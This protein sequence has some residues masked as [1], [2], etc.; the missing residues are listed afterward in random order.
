MLNSAA[1]AYLLRV[2]PTKL[3]G[4]ASDGPFHLDQTVDLYNDT[5]MVI[6]ANMMV[7]DSV[8]NCGPNVSV[9]CYIDGAVCSNCESYGDW[10]LD[11]I[12]KKWVCVVRCQNCRSVGA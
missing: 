1:N 11:P 8:K 4:I 12:L 7:V 10:D 9:Y 2:S 5:S 3:C 6:T